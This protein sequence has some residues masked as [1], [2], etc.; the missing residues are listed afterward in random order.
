MKKP[1]ITIR[2]LCDGEFRAYVGRC[3][4]EFVR[5]FGD[6]KRLKPRLTIVGSSWLYESEA[7]AFAAE[8]QTAI[9]I[10]QQGWAWLDAQR[11]KK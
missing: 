2:E 6:R 3:Q 8:L 11:K 7:R 5:S 10:M 4:V 9:K 1:K